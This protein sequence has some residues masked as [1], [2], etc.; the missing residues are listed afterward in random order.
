M[1]ISG[2][3]LILW[4][5][6]PSFSLE[7]QISQL[8]I[9]GYGDFGYDY[10]GESKNTSSSIKLSL[11]FGAAFYR[12]IGINLYSNDGYLPNRIGSTSQDI[13]FDWIQVFLGRPTKWIPTLLLEQERFS[14]YIS[15]SG[16]TT[17]ID[18]NGASFDQNSIIPLQREQATAHLFWRPELDQLEKYGTSFGIGY[19][20]IRITGT[21]FEHL[22]ANWSTAQL[23]KR[24][25]G[26]GFSFIGR[27]RMYRKNLFYPFSLEIEVDARV[28]T[29][30]SAGGFLKA[31]YVIAF[32]IGQKDRFQ[33][34]PF[35]GGYWWPS[36]IYG[37]PYRGFESESG[38]EV[39]AKIFFKR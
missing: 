12:S 19:G 32:P 16:F 29:T 1:T 24:I 36:F 14:G 28:A 18:E 39:G 33:I 38:Y 9:L 34:A 8:R 25:E 21:G 27:G 37:S 4:L 17:F 2:L 23:G 35:L 20:Y 30:D 22:D 7:Y 5:N 31:G 3:I 11:D 6:G 26:K 15:P 10:V 13:S